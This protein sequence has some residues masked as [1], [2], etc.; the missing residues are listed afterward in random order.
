MKRPSLYERAERAALRYVDAYLSRNQP[1]HYSSRLYFEAG[2]LAGYKA[3]K[4]ERK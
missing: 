4:R 1:E 2:Y 3:A